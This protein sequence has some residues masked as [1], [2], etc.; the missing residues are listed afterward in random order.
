MRGRDHLFFLPSAGAARL[1]ALPVSQARP[2]TSEGARAPC[3]RIGRWFSGRTARPRAREKK[4]TDAAR[5]AAAF[6]QDSLS[7]SPPRFGASADRKRSAMGGSRAQGTH[8]GRGR[9][10]GEPGARAERACRSLSVAEPC[11]LALFAAL[12]L[13]LLR[14]I[15][16]KARRCRG[17]AGKTLYSCSVCGHERER[18]RDKAPTAARRVWP[19]YRPRNRPSL[20]KTRRATPHT[21]PPRH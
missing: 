20:A 19:A 17:G 9:H 16:M 6:W 5:G 3:P 2:Q 15:H 13:V 11:L 14:R 1:S 10:F 12:V 18:R 8:L 21:F 4:K 7:V